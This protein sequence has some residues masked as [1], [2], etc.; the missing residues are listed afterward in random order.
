MHF[1]TRVMLCKITNL[2]AICK[3]NKQHILLSKGHTENRISSKVSYYS[4]HKVIIFHIYKQSGRN[5]FVD[6]NTYL[7]QFLGQFPSA[8]N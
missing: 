7:P 3:G 5:S 6:V 1:V 8:R 4:N 2:P